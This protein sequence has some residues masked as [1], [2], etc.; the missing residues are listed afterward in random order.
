MLVRE[1]SHWWGTL[2]DA[3]D[4][5]ELARFYH[6]L[7][8]WPITHETPNYAIISP[9]GSNT[10]L[11]FQRA[12]GYERPTWPNVPGRQQMMMHLDLEVGDLDASVAAAVDAG[13][14]LAG[15][16]PQ[17]KVRVLLDPAGHPFCLYVDEPEPAA[18]GGG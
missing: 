1:P 7:L 17:E 18:G 4:P 14:T 15:F 2:L 8:G 6:R 13:A 16:Q 3:A 5:V 10:Y 9:P 11:G 12:D